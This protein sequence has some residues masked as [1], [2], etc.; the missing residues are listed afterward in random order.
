MTAITSVLMKIPNR[1]VEERMENVDI[2]TDPRKGY[3]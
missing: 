1:M 2:D 3:N